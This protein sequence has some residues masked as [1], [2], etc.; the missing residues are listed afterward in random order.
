[1]DYFTWLL[2]DSNLFVNSLSTLFDTIQVKEG[3]ELKRFVSLTKRIMKKFALFFA[4]LLTTCVAAA[5]TP[6]FAVK[7]GA[8]VANWS[9]DDADDASARFAYKVGV[10]M[11]LPF[12]ST[13]SLQTGLNFVSKG[14]EADA[15]IGDAYGKI[16]VNQLYLEL[17]IMAAARFAIA[18]NTQ[19]VI[20]GG[21]YLAY[22]VG[23]KTDVE[24]GIPGA[25]LSGEVDTFGGDGVDLR[26]FDWGL[27]IG[28]AVEFDHFVVGL[29]GQFGLNKLHPDL[30]AKN[31]SAFVTVG[32][33][34]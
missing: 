25:A 19:I 18:D 10:G 33:K 2:L 21:P 31:L 15:Y 17:P 23:G 29:D 30:K 7:G 22:G 8:G 9:G 5:Q 4:L 16:E 27:G 12:T 28:A 3:G 26:R 13:W 34:F 24:A 6:I 32:Y 1:M 20:S 11:E 14:T